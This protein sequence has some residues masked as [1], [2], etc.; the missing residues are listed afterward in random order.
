MTYARF[1]ALLVVASLSDA[2]A[3]AQTC[4]SWSQMKTTRESVGLCICD[5]N[6]RV[7]IDCDGDAP[8]GD[9]PGCYI[10]P[11]QV[12]WEYTPGGCTEWCTVTHAA[13]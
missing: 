11:C 2:T 7:V 9:S 13:N 4:G 5:C 1:G 12:A 8:T 6:N 10:S 3:A